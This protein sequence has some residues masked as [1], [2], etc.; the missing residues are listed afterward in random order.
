ME[1]LNYHAFGLNVQTNFELFSIPKSVFTSKIDLL[2]NKGSDQFNVPIDS[3]RAFVK[4]EVLDGIIYHVQDVATFL[5]RKND[6]IEIQQISKDDDLVE[7]ILMNGVIN[8]YLS[9]KGYFVFNGAAI[10]VKNRAHLF[11]GRAGVGLSSIVSKFHS[12]RFQ[13]L[14][15]NQVVI[16]R[17]GCDWKIVPSNTYPKLWGRVVDELDIHDKAIKPV[18]MSLDKYYVD[19]LE[20]KYPKSYEISNQYVIELNTSG[21]FELI[22][23]DISGLQA[24]KELKNYLV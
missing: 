13:I 21:K 14:S 12:K 16:K 17:V 4:K 11:V 3:D 10:L 7:S 23:K 1:R 18:R 8:T 5:I 22:S 6:H 24:I 9:S 19:L 20:D 2:I 15:D